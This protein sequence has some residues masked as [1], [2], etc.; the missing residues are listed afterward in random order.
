MNKKPLAVEEGSSLV[1]ETGNTLESI[2]DSVKHLSQIVGEIAHASSEQSSGI[3]MFKIAIH[4]IDAMTQQNAALVEQGNT[5]SATL[6]DQAS[7]LSQSVAV[8]KY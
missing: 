6:K 8:F 2:V 5:T 1:N 4:E 3:E 7:E